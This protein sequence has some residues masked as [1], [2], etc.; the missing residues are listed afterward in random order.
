MDLPSAPPEDAHV[1]NVVREFTEGH[2]RGGEFRNAPIIVVKCMAFGEYWDDIKRDVDQ[3]HH[4]SHWRNVERMLLK[5]DGELMG[6][7]CI[8]LSHKLWD[9]WHRSRSQNGPLRVIIAAWCKSG[10]DRSVGMITFLANALARVGWGGAPPVHICGGQRGWRPHTA[11]TP[12][13]QCLPCACQDE[14][15]TFFR[16]HPRA[17]LPALRR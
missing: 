4:G 8:E 14:V 3:G 7:V 1:K 15:E 6:Q 17:M 13:V 16:R 10:R 2:R 5:S 12:C 11:S 9:L